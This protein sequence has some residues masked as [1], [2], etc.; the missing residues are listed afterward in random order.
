MIT[1]Q[2]LKSQIS[3][4]PETGIFTWIVAKKGVSKGKECGRISKQHGY[5]DIHIDGK[6]Y[7]AHQLAFLYMNGVF[8]NSEI[9]HINRN[10]SDNRWDNLR[11][12]TKSQNAANVGLKK[13]NTTGAKG[14]VWD[15]D[16][17][18]WRVQIRINGVKKNLGRFDNFEDAVKVSEN[19]LK[20]QFGEFNPANKHEQH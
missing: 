18:K 3:Y 12:C 1:Q 4:C 20:K 9:D 13:S 11:V 5:K 19:A 6:F 15:K 8:A 7:R 17:N 2:R 10:R 16:R 14:V